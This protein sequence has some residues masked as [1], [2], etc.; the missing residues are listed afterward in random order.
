M[1]KIAA[2]VGIGILTFSDAFAQQDST[3]NRTVIVE[4]EYNPTVMDASKINVMPKTNEPKATKK[5]INYATSLRKVSAW[6]YQTMSP[7]VREWESDAVYRGYLRAGYGNQGNVDLGLGY[8][9]DISKK[10][11]LNVSASL[12]GFNAE[13]TD[14]D[15]VARLYNTRAGLDYKHS[16]KKVD[17]LLGGKF[18]SQ[19]FNYMTD[20]EDQAEGE[21]SNKQHRTLGNAYMGFVTTGREMPLQFAGELGFNYWD[22]KYSLPGSEKA[23]ENNLYVK[24][25]V[26]KRLNNVHRF[27]LGVRFDNYSYSSGQMDDA[28]ALDFKPYYAIQSENWNIRIGA[29]V[30]WWGGEDDKLYLS[31]DVNVEHRFAGSYVLY[32][33]AGGGRQITGLYE[34]TDVTPYWYTGINSPVYMN[35]DAALGLKG[36]PTEGFW[37]HVSGGYQIRENDIC[38]DFGGNG[39]PLYYAFNWTGDTKV[40]YG[41]AELRYDYK[42]LV[43]FS[44]AGTYYNWKWESTDW[45]GGE[46]LSESALSLKPE[47]EMNVKIGAKVM[48]GLRAH[49]GYEYVKRTGGIYEPVSNLH[50]GAT[51]ALWKNFRVYGKINNLLNKEYIGTDAY[52]AQGLNFLAGLSVQF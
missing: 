18:H 51:Y 17:F 28:A 46:N 43:D 41:A 12:D 27:G 29:H 2:I 38:L 9:W 31:P 48:A 26:G 16:F 1:R 11:R 36:S 14:E 13:L 19:V 42:D 37:F 50:V 25:E 34:L 40:L 10:D 22:S 7:V 4:N 15:Y 20:D 35:L 47:L 5:N 30:D 44:I 49:V 6:D 23:K 8:L 52:P 21:F 39:Y 3:L 24:G 33:K 45:V 32:A